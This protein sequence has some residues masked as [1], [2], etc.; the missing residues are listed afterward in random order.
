MNARL[1]AVTMTVATA[2]SPA[3]AGVTFGFTAD[4]YGRT[5]GSGQLEAGQGSHTVLDLYLTNQSASDLRLLSVYDLNLSLGEGEFVHDDADTDNAGDGLVRRLQHARRERG[6]RQLRHARHVGGRPVRRRSPEF[7]RRGKRLG[8]CGLVQQRSDQ[9]PGQHRR[10]RS[11]V[12]HRFVVENAPLGNDLHRLE[13]D[14]PQLQTPGVY[15]DSDSQVFTLPRRAPGRWPCRPR[16][17]RL[18]IAVG[19]A[20]TIHPTLG[21]ESPRPPSSW[22]SRERRSV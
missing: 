21:C 18:A 3:V 4:I 20:D 17:H 11:G 13:H 10:G 9:R 14:L 12:R 16:R 8:R 7:R 19:I 6:H 15:F 5:A 22:R 2:A 1:L